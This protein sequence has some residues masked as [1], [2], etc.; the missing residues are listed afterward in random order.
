MTKLPVQGRKPTDGPKRFRGEPT[1]DWVEVENVP[2]EG[3]PDLPARAP[4]QVKVDGETVTVAREWPAQALRKWRVWSTMPHCILWNDADWEYAYDCLEVA[5]SFL[6]TSAVGLATELR[7]REKLLGIT[8]D[9]RRDL[10]IRYVEPAAPKPA[11]KIVTDN[12]EDL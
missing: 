10:R 1:H 6:E 2:F 4:G 3:A 8:A 7:N 12:F 11:L 9:Y 5:A